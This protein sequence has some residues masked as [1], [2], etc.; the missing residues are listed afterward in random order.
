MKR[1]MLSI[2]AALIFV[3]TY[4]A[5]FAQEDQKACEF[6]I[7]GTWQSTTGGHTN[8]TRLRF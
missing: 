2:L 6:N 4:L 7:A 8:P 1:L 5:A 3:P